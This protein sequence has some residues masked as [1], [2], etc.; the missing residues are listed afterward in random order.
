MYGNQM[1]KKLTHGTMLLRRFC[2]V[3]LLLLAGF[4]Q[5]T[6]ANPPNILLLVA[7]DLG[8]RIGSFGDNQARTPNLDA[9]AQQSTRFTKVFT[10]A[11][12]C[13]PSRAALITGQHQ[14]SFGAQH[15]RTSTSPLG[16]YLAQPA[17]NLR[18]L[19]ELLRQLGYYT[20]T[21][22]KLD[23]QF[24][25]IRPGSGPFSLWDAQGRRAEDWRQ[26][27]PG[28]P[29]FGLINFMHTHESGVMRAS[30][31]SYSNGHTQSQRMRK[32]MG[33]VADSITDPAE[34]KLPPY[35]P[36]LPEV[37]ADI[38]R[39]YD[40][41]HAM[42]KRVGEILQA[43]EED[44][45]A[46]STV[47]IWT[48]DH[49]DGL[50]RA[51]RE[52]FDSGIHVPLLLRKPGQ[53]KAAVDD[54]LVSFVD[55]A[56]TLYALAQGTPAADYWH[57][58]DV[59]NAKLPERNYVYASRDRIDEVDDRQRAI[60]SERFKYI[61]SYRPD[62][63]GGHA[64][65]YRD[66]LDMVRAWRSAYVSNTLTS[67][68]AAWFQAPGAEQLYDL[69]ADP[70]EVRNL[71]NDPAYANTLATLSRQLDSFLERV[72]DTS[73]VAET[74]LRADF[75]VDGQLRQTPPPTAQW[76][77]GTA[78]LTSPIGASIGYR[79]HPEQPWQLYTQPIAAESFEAKSVRYGWAESQTTN[80]SSAKSSAEEK[81]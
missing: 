65:S 70:H 46:N 21:D 78:H 1:R 6:T 36:D 44:G 60:R 53:T 76:R 30:G 56:P 58:Q 48:T 54:Q 19:P 51:K 29:F 71:A 8:P 49:G 42:D 37:R 26:R 59:L 16:A 2:T 24:S 38:A 77:S 18:A 40:N 25:G 52:L 7:E 45:L 27:K 80:F 17:K 68:Q 4:V 41:I 10:T 39:H 32:A 14:I 3:S 64:L 47:V 31:P 34:V 63:P 73:N 33:L 69:E 22:N 50:P 5:A 12:V 66:N 75:L 11:G 62:I 35:Y 74:Q 55:L 9:L 20:Y 67:V 28:Q 61:R 72:D 79:L 23:Y 81:P 57:G 13:A 43:L 15:M